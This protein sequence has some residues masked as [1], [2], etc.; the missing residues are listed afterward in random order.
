[1]TLHIGRDF[2]LNRLGLRL[3]IAV[4]CLAWLFTAGAAHAQSDRVTA[5]VVANELRDLN[6]KPDVEPSEDGDPQIRVRVDNF[7]WV[8]FFFNCDKSG[9][10]ERRGCRSLQF[11]TSYI[12]D[13]AIPLATINSW[14]TDQRYAR[15]YYRKQNDG[16]HS[17]R[18]EVDALFEDTGSKPA[19]AFRAYFSIMKRQAA[20]FRKHIGF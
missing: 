18:I 19:E 1:M 10:L 3:S 12:M 8:I 6:L 2:K 7:L 16:K 17:A 14:N 13:N 20:S 11:Y 15:A 4:A 9:E 5:R